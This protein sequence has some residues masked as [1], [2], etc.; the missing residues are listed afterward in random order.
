MEPIV[1]S[2]ICNTHNHEDYIAKS[3]ESLLMQ[4]V[5]FRYEI[6]LHDDAS[7][8]NT[9]NIVREYEKKYPDII[10]PIY[11][12]ENQYTK[13]LGIS[14]RFQY[15]RVQGK[16]VAFCEGDDYWTDPLKLQKQYDYLEAHPNI[17]MCVHGA[18]AVDQKNEKII[19]KIAPSKK[20][21]IMPMEEVIMGDGVYVVSNSM[22]FRADVIKGELPEFWKQF[23]YQFCIKLKAA[24]RGG[25]YYMSDIMSAYR[26]QA[27]GSWTSKMKKDPQ[28]WYDFH[29]KKRNMFKLLDEYTDY[30]YTE[31]IQEKINLDKVYLLWQTGQYKKVLVKENKK[32]FKKF[33]IKTRILCY[34]NVYMPWLKS[35]YKKV[36]RKGK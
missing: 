10:K 28:K 26:L 14:S 29:E 8:D 22:F 31:T 36:R 4:K 18:V 7:E 2:V 20:S 34:V 1:V 19:S 35:F 27:K 12:T 25:I 30:K 5:N 15:C 3:L 6:L 24:I 23:R 17:D 13:G 16:Y 21:R 11:Q 32:Y 9:A 33:P